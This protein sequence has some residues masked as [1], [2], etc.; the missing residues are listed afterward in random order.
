VIREQGQLNGVANFIWGIADDA[1]AV[2]RHHVRLRSGRGIGW[3]LL[4]MGLAQVEPRQI[5]FGR[6]YIAAFV[7]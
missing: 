7:M 4:V 3:L 2:L 1:A 6:A 5:W